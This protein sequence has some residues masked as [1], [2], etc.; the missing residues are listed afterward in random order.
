MHVSDALIFTLTALS[1]GSSP[2]RSL[3][4]GSHCDDFSTAP[5]VRH[6]SIRLGS[7]LCPPGP[8]PAVPQHQPWQVQ[9]GSVQHSRTQEAAGRREDA[10]ERDPARERCGGNVK[11]GR[12]GRERGRWGR[13][14][15]GQGSATGSSGRQHCIQG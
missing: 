7:R 1:L 14:D 15:T 6:P 12:D 2:A 10:G 11:R 9:D 5:L 13:R 4:P 8:P 3:G